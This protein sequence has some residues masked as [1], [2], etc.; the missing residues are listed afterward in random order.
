M[1]LTEKTVPPTGLW[2]WVK[3]ICTLTVVGVV[4]YKIYVT[5]MSLTVDFPTL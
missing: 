5:P 3:A 2:E 1:K 4:A